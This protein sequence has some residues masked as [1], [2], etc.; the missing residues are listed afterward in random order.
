MST[1][2]SIPSVNASY[3]YAPAIS[4]SLDGV[5]ANTSENR[6]GRSSVVSLSDT[7]VLYR[8]AVDAGGVVKGLLDEIRSALVHADMDGVVAGSGAGRYTKQAE[9]AV[10]LR[11]VEY[12]VAEAEYKGNNL[13]SSAGSTLRVQ[14]TQYG[15]TF[16]VSPNPLDGRGLN[17]GELSIQAVDLRALGLDDFGIIS[18]SDIE[19]ALRRIDIAISIADQRLN[20]VGKI[21]AFVNASNFIQQVNHLNVSVDATSLPAGTFIDQ[22]A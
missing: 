20:A 8:K 2:G 10:L 6:L 14:T 3:L 12:A 15:G 11:K 16:T 1:V 17:L 5:R 9:I 7:R 19:G 21:D 4:S 22:V 18:E 13:I